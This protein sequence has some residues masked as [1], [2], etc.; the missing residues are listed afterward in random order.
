[1]FAVI[2]VL[3]HARK[4]HGREYSL[5]IKTEHAVICDAINLGWVHL[6]ER[7]GWKTENRGVRI[8]NLDLWKAYAELA[9]RKFALWMEEPKGHIDGY[10]SENAQM[11]AYKG[12]INGAVDRRRK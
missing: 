4:E 8:K 12:A 5:T 1:M 2:H 11:L 3:R 7:N 10:C 9:D 6:W